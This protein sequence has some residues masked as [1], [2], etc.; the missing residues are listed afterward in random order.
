MSDRRQ[1]NQLELALLTESRGEAP[2]AVSGG[3]ESLT[4]KRKT[5]SPAIPKQLMEEVV[6][7]EN[8]NSFGLPTLLAGR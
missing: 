6:E 4:A 3:T 2:M 7:R 8:V 5:E 1:K